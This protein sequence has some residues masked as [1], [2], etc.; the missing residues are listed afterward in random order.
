MN[1]LTNGTSC[2]C[3]HYG[4]L[5]KLAVSFGVSVSNAVVL[6]FWPRYARVKLCERERA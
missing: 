2:V 6:L 1:F 5:E 3:P 4:S